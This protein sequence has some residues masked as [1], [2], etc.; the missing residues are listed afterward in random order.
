[1]KILWVKAGKILPVDTGGHI[2]SYNILRRLADRHDVTFLSHYGG[3]KDEIYERQ[4][5]HELPGAVP[6]YARSWDFRPLERRVNYLLRLPLGVPF[7]IAKFKSKPAQRL[8]AQWLVERRFDAAICDF[9]S[10]APNFPRVLDIPVVLF[11]HNVETVLWRRQAQMEAYPPRRLAFQIEARRMGRYE[12]R[13]VRRF[14][15][16]I[17]VSEVDRERMS[18]MTDAS[19]ITVIPTGVDLSLYKPDPAA[20][21]DPSL[22]VFV[23]TMDWQPNM[24]GVEY[25]CRDIWPRILAR[26]PEARFR[27]V[28]RSPSL[29]VRRLACETVTVTGTVPSVVEHFREAAVVVVP[30]RIGG[31]TRLKILEAMAVG[32]AVV[33]TSVGAEGLDV[34][35]GHDIILAD[36]PDNFAASVVELIRNTELRRRYESAAAKLAEGYD[37]SV[38]AA[39]FGNVLEEVVKRAAM[40]NTPATKATV[41]A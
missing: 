22:V 34:H 37:W 13:A 23:G 7:A 14:H 30:L 39:R 3:H 4:I 17:A 15:H 36:D 9:L 20:V 41:N 21:A 38:I 31:G 12:C 33:S 10:A 40:V 18:A 5:E 26:H 32:K 27:I 16:V 28:G 29:P 35:P 1:M 2:R 6:L 24:D 8:I 25:F 11:Q 19:R